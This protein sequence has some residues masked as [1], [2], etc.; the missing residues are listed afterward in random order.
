MTTLQDCQALDAQ[1]PLRALR[2][3][4]AAPAVG[5]YG[6]SLGAWQS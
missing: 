2:A 4:H 1:D 3:E 5:I 6:V